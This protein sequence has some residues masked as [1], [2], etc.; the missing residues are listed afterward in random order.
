MRHKFA[1]K[2]EEENRWTKR[3]ASRGCFR[4]GRVG[5]RRLGSFRWPEATAPPEE[6]GRQRIKNTKSPTGGKRT[7]TDLR[8]EKSGGGT[9]CVPSFGV[10]RRCC[11]S[12]LID[13]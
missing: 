8:Q 13:S 7:Y 11:P 5:I 12:D 10:F 9:V 2:R 4:D 3:C 6:K 1:S